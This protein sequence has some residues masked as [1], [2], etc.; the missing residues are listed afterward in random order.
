MD[1]VATGLEIT[2]GIQDMESNMPLVANRATW[3]RGYITQVNPDYPL[4][5]ADVNARL[6]GYR[7]S[8][9]IG[10]G[11]IPYSYVTAQDDGGN[12][13]LLGDSFLFYVPPSWRTGT[14]T[15]E[16]EVNPPGAG[17][18]EEYDTTN[19]KIT[20]VLTFN[21]VTT[22]CLIMV[23]IHLHGDEGDIT[24]HTTDAGFERILGGMKRYH[25]IPNTISWWNQPTLYPAG[26]DG[27][28]HWDLSN[29]F[30]RQSM[31]QRIRW[32]NWWNADPEGGCHYVGM[33]SPDADTTKDTGE[34][35]GLARVGGSESWVKMED[36]TPDKAPA[37]YQ[38]GAQTL[39]HE[40]GHNKGLKHAN[41]KGDEDNTDSA[42]PWPHPACAL[43]A[44][45][46]TGYYGLTV[47][48][49]IWGID[50]KVISNDR[51]AAAPHRA[52]PVMG[53]Q[54][55]QWVSPWEYCKLLDTAYGVTCNLWSWSSIQALE[56]A[57]FQD[58]ASLLSPEE[59]ARFEI[60]SNYIVLGGLIDTDA[61]TAEI[62]EVYQLDEL[63][64]G[65]LQE[66]IRSLANQ[67]VFGVNGSYALVQVDQS[68]GVLDSQSLSLL[69]DDEDDG[70][71]SFLEALPA[72]SGVTGIQVREGSTILDSRLA[73]D[74]PPTVQVISPNG[75]ETLSA[76]FLISWTASDQDGGDLS[77]DVSYSS[78]DGATWTL[79]EMGLDGTSWQL[80]SLDAIP[81]T[82]QGRIRVLANDGFNTAM[83]ISD[84]A[85][86]VPN[87][88]PQALIASP[89]D[90]STV[91][92]NELLILEAMSFD[93]EDGPN[94]GDVTWTSSIDGF[95]GSERE[96]ATSGLSL[97]VHQITLS[98]EDSE[99]LQGTDSVTVT[100]GQDSWEVYIP[101]LCRD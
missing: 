60:V 8:V 10:S 12:R 79:L 64:A 82:D 22:P 96:F 38:E 95:L 53:Y 99:G 63:P 65:M 69:S 21:S 5:V 91:V 18:I 87:S 14:V 75:G 100:V 56:G 94:V 35:L 66:A 101:M 15:F 44:N 50:R 54:R 86:S 40:L 4:G 97:G 57:A 3:A 59:L 39:A 72:A 88:P 52:Y 28:A 77:F 29:G 58:P 27:G 30:D 9:E 67:K 84:G 92:A 45:D 6:H 16:L 68:G 76:G 11:L 46:P 33:V 74:N 13:L 36:S 93:N 62:Q 32:R 70:L 7:N 19:N 49:A 78:D 17:Q 71:Y 31:L 47:Y 20:E 98:V 37:W 89:G 90:G 26:H 24:Y 61:N 51:T 34:V 43:A 42:Y 48:Q 1:I 83:D 41:C 55:Y 80:A 25:P 73:S 85:F 23:P 81:G 2:Q